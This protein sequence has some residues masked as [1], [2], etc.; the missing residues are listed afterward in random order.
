MQSTERF[1]L[2]VVLVAA[3]LLWADAAVP[4]SYSDACALWDARYRP[5]TQNLPQ[6]TGAHV[7]NSRCDQAGDQANVLG[8]LNWYR[9][10]AGL[11]NVT[12]NAT[13]HSQAQAVVWAYILQRCITIEL[14]DW[15]Q[16]IRLAN[17]SALNPLFDVSGA[18]LYNYP[19]E[20]LNP[21]LTDIGVGTFGNQTLAPGVGQALHMRTNATTALAPSASAWFAFPPDGVMEIAALKTPHW[22]FAT[23]QPL[24][25]AT[26][27]LSLFDLSNN[28]TRAEYVGYSVTQ[29]NG[30]FWVA[31]SPPAELITAGR[32]FQVYITSNLTGQHSWTYRPHL[33][34][35]S[36]GESAD[37]C[38]GDCSEC[39][40]LPVQFQQGQPAKCTNGTWLVS[41][42]L[43]VGDAEVVYA[44]NAPV[45]IV[46]NIVLQPT[47]TIRFSAT[48]KDSFGAIRL[49]GTLVVDIDFRLDTRQAY[50][51]TI[52]SAA[53]GQCGASAE[54][55][56][57][58]QTGGPLS[59]FQKVKINFNQNRQCPPNYRS[60]TSSTS[61]AVLIKPSS[62]GCG[63]DD[64]T[65]LTA[66]I[67][68]LVG[69]AVVLVVVG[70]V[71]GL[72]AAWFK[73]RR[74]RR[75]MASVHDRL[76]E[77]EM[78]EVGPGV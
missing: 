50:T 72:V 60:A 31:F 30:W 22:Q 39:G 34:N 1:L 43:E 24:D 67:A 78:S 16:Q 18:Y 51:F 66:L 38:P 54:T 53:E 46:G 73:S 48:G 59:S 32:H 9:G 13:K 25:S 5:D 44:G 56:A 40:P 3:A 62:S 12:A 52:V 69:G 36:P 6:W 63:G 58:R 45:E 26:T 33:A 61:Y 23:T 11:P 41:G 77:H 55:P 4:R 37:A 35:C 27:T 68:G 76:R 70:I 29:A 71:A 15:S 47:A 10:V 17:V 75:A 20:I 2:L 21:E 8:Q 74:R 57:R 49:N 65:L 7:D 64:N 42:A 19:Q 28:F 14:V